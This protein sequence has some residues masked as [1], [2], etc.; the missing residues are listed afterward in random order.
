MM[1][2]VS[3][4]AIDTTRVTIKFEDMHLLYQKNPPKVSIRK[5]ICEKSDNLQV[6]TQPATA[7]LSS[8]DR[9]CRRW[10]CES[11][12]GRGMFNIQR[13]PNPRLVCEHWLLRCAEN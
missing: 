6:K 3:S 9:R 13:A 11:G 7:M 12:F 4:S 5:I 8:V 2:V 10:F 1:P